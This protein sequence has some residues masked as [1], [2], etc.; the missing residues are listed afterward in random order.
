MENKAVEDIV[1]ELILKVQVG[2]NGKAGIKATDLAPYLQHPAYE[3]IHRQL[4]E[5]MTGIDNEDEKGMINPL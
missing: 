2:A 1:Q 3:E 4:Y 5:Y